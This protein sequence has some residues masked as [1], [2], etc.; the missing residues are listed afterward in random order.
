MAVGSEAV[1]WEAEETEAGMTAEERAGAA[2]E[3][4][5][6]VVVS[7]RLRVRGEGD[8]KAAPVAS[9]LDGAHAHLWRD[10]P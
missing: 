1:G 4:A 3:A 8:V 6:S 2:M 7:A 10:L 5:G 9:P